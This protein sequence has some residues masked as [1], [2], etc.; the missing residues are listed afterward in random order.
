MLRITLKYLCRTLVP[1]NINVIFQSTTNI[2]YSGKKEKKR[3]K[4]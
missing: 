3:I 1:S 4:R 2:I